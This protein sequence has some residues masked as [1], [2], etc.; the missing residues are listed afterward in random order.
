MRKIW[1]LKYTN[2]QDMD[3]KPA[4]WTNEE[5]Y[6]NEQDIDITPVKWTNEHVLEIA[7]AKWTNEQ[8]RGEQDAQWLHKD[9]GTLALPKG[10]SDYIRSEQGSG[11]KGD[12]VLWNTGEKFRQYICPNLSVWVQVLVLV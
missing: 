5:K 2:E 6:T 9:S 1:T 11:P 7:P 4:K 10:C 3:I 12:D 8:N